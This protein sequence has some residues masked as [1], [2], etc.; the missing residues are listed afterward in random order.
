MITGSFCDIHSFLTLYQSIFIFF[1]GML[2]A[3]LNSVA[4]GGSFIGFPALVLAGVPAIPSNVANNVAMWM[5]AVGSGGAYRNRLDVSKRVLAPLLIASIC[6][7]LVGALLLL[8]T[9]AHTFVRTIPWLMLGATL[10]FI[11]GKRL[12]GLRHLTVSHEATNTAIVVTS[13]LQFLIAIYGGYF[14]A[15]MSIV[16]LAML[17]AA[18][19]V[20]IHAMN[21]LKSVLGVAVT[22]VATLYFVFSRAVWWPQA[23]VMT[24]GAIVGGYCGAHFA[25]RLPRTWVRG[26]VI[27]VAA[28]MTTYFFVKT[29]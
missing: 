17:A 8:K 9:P 21:A 13:F 14:G 12:A 7:G 23:A 1:S 6:G 2:G 18:G 15:G 19:M 25:Q 20:D 27:L 22:G 16:V 28:G 24:L 11:F 29:Y 4:G 26:F 3:G 10:L 5:G